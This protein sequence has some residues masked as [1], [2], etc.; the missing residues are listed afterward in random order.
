MYNYNLIKMNQYIRK[1]DCAVCGGKVLYNT[2]TEKLKC[3]CGEVSPINVIDYR[4]LINN[5][6]KLDLNTICINCDEDKLTRYNCSE[7]A[8][9]SVD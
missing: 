7:C 4:V 1:W 6:D 2:Y 9:K 8:V 3:K 5:F